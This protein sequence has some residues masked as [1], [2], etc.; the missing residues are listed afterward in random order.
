MLAGNVIADIPVIQSVTEIEDLAKEK[1]VVISVKKRFPVRSIGG[2]DDL[3]QQFSQQIQFSGSQL[4]R[5]IEAIKEKVLNWTIE[6]EQRGVL[7]DDMTFSEEEKKTASNQVF[8]IQRFNGVI[9]SVNHSNLQIY[10]YNLVHQTLKQQG[11]P[12]KERNELENLM[13]DLGKASH[14]EKPKVLKR[15]EAWIVRNEKILGAGI[16]LI[17]KA[18]GLDTN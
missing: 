7:G 18:L 14:S 16:G 10:D 12:Q 13:D 4:R 8:N 2:S 1:T 15:A 17:R 6:L 11:V 9:G 5:V 3:V